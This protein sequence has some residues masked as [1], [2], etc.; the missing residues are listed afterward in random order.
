M[1]AILYKVCRVLYRKHLIPWGAW[2]FVYDHC[3]RAVSDPWG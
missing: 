3:H 1:R 2:S